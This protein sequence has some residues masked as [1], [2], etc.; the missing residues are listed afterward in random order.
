MKL[1]TQILAFGLAG[2][3]LTGMAGIIGMVTSS[4]MSGAL[5]DALSASQALQTSQAADMMHDAIRG[6]AQLALLGALQHKP[7]VIASAR[8]GLEDHAETIRR[9]LDRLASMS[10]GDSARKALDRARPAVD[11]YVQTA[12]AMVEG[13]SSGPEAAAARQPAL[14]TRFEALE[15]ELEAL[16][17]VLKAE[18]SELDTAARASVDTTRLAIGAA[19]AASTVALMALALWLTG[20]MTRPMRHAVEAAERLAQGDLTA[21]IEPVG[22]EET[23]ALLAAFARMQSRLADLVR[24]V[25]GNADQVAGASAQIAQ[26][27]MDLSNRTEQQASALQQTAATMSQLGDTVRNNAE[28]AEQARQLADGAVEVAD[29]GGAVM[30]RVVETMSG[31]DQ[32]SRRIADIIGTIDGIAFQTNILA[33]NAAVEAAR[34]GEQGRG[35][36]VVAGEVRA[37]AQRS[38]EAA[39]EIKSLVTASVERVQAGGGQVEEAGRTVAEMVAAIRRVNDL[40]AEISAASRAQSCSLSEVGSAVAE[41]DR[42]TQQSAALVEQTAS[43]AESLKGQADALVRAVGAFHV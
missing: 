35:F 18:G 37:L 22:N 13:A 25:Q 15:N 5:S 12:Q 34:A 33:L 4:R 28:N 27:N 38:A 10:M 32:S 8:K 29:R 24:E 17:E 23:R 40:V 9:D 31:I 6:D 11:A 43:A 16:S 39:R 30:A 36:A 2:A 1:R 20:Q 41:M 7:E 19:M 42:G 21:T 3:L 14:Q 26:G